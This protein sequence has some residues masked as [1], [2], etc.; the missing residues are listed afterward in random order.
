[1]TKELK[2]GGYTEFCFQGVGGLKTIRRDLQQPFFS[3]NNTLLN[4]F[5]HSLPYH[6]SEFR[7]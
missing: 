7:A 6:D 2:G 4:F 5:C 1:M 3:H